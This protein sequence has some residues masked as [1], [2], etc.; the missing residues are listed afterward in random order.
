MGFFTLALGGVG[1]LLVGLWESLLSSSPSPKLDQSSI[2]HGTN[3]RRKYPYFSSVTFFAIALLSSLFICNSLYSLIDAVKSKD[4]VGSP[5]QL[6]MLAI[7]F[8]FLLYSVLGILMKLTDSIPLPSSFLSLIS[9]FAFAEE[10]LLFYLQRKDTVGIENRYFDM[11]LVPI[12]ICLFSTILEF[13]SSQSNLPRLVRGIGLVLQG[14][15]LLQMAVSFFT[16]CMVH[17]CRLHEK[18]SGNY[19]V[20][21]KGHPE[22]HRGRAIATLQFNCHLAFVVVFVVAVFSFVSRRNGGL[23]FQHYRPIGEALPSLS[24]TGHFTLDSDD[25][26]VREEENVEKRKPA[27]IEMGVNGH[28]SYQ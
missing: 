17:G 7:G 5:L 26:E 14:T 4:K 8:L 25:D 10:F 9:F 6:Q 28:V 3:P 24:H 13:K 2:T 11:M 16:S 19:T 15:W 1:F 20:R 12:T 27:T 23:D 21:C 22:Y 18:S